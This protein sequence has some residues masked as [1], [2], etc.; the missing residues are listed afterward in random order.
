MS[1][2][3]FA[4]VRK[5]YDCAQVASFLL[6][7]NR[8]FEEK[9]GQ[10]NAEIKRLT[11]ALEAER[12][13]KA[14]LLAEAGEKNAALETSLQ[15]KE[16][17]C[18]DLKTKLGTV[19]DARQKA[20]EILREANDRS[21]ELLQAARQKGNAEAGQ[22]VNG[23]RQKAAILEWTI[24]D[25]SERMTEIQNEVIK[26][27]DILSDAIHELEKGIQSHGEAE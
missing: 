15:E 25:F 18:E 21:N 1:E 3:V 2:P 17:E 4:K 23:V 10:L 27:E 12:A 20:K 14:R 7:M 16:A 19:D 9:E 13:D 22:L 8:S 11:V 6:E 26:A 5:G 24:S